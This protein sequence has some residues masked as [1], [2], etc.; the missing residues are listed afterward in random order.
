MKLRV[1]SGAH[2]T[3]RAED[4]QVVAEAPTSAGMT[5]LARDWRTLLAA[6]RPLRPGTTRPAHAMRRLVCRRTP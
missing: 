6:A 1:P 2:V 4:V 5:H 3:A